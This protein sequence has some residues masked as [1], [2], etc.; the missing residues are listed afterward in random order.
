MITARNKYGQ[1]AIPE[2]S[3]NRTVAVILKSG[4]VYEEETIEYI[5]DNR[6][7]GAVVHA[8]AYI[9]DFLPALGADNH[10]VYAFEAVRENCEYAA[11]TLE[12]NFG[13][14]H[15][16]ELWQRALGAT[17]DEAVKIITHDYNGN[18]IGCGSMIEGRIHKAEGTNFEEVTTIT[19]DTV[20][21]EDQHVSL[22]HLD[23]EGFEEQA[24]KGALKTIE[25]C[26]PILVLECWQDEMLKTSFY[27]DKIF[28]IGYTVAGKVCENVILAP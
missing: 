19:I 10:K 8:G 12:L 26:K 5:L 6:G 21:P 18:N 3:V 11:K 2:S 7:D 16:V 24:L 17:D 20:V 4:R 28:G 1:Y 27:V 23:V 15:H 13:F 14:N 25:R 22:I 9:G